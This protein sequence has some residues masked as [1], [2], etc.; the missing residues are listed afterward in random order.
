MHISTRIA[1][2]LDCQL[3]E[4]ICMLIELS[5]RQRGTGIARRA[6]KFIQEKILSGKAIIAFTEDE[7]LAGFCYIQSWEQG[8]Y[9]AHSGLVVHPKFRQKGVAKKVKKAAFELARQRYPEAKIF[10]ITTSLAVMKINS[11]L[12]YQP[13]TFSELTQDDAFWKGCESCQ[14]FDILQRN[15]RRLCL[16]TGMLALPEPPTHNL[17]HLILDQH[18]K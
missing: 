8:R 9:V 15:Q 12:G 14:N 16:C 10:G 6:P 7:Q 11:E 5:A 17:T 1:T 2:A 4:D 18:E 13:V 3:A